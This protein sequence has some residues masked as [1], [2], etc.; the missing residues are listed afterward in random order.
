M[1]MLLHDS[2]KSFYRQPA[3]PLPA[4]SEVTIRLQCDE[5]TSV[6]LRTWMDEELCYTMLPT[7]KNVWELGVLLPNH[8]GLFWYSFIVY[9]ED[10]HT[11]RYGN[12]YDKLGGEGAV[13][14]EGDTESFQITVYDL[15]YATPDY[16]HGANIYQ[17]FPDRFWR[18]ATQSID[19][20]TDRHVHER[21]NEDLLLNDA[22]GKSDEYMPLDF[23]GGT[24][25]GIQEK[26][27][28]LKSLGVDILYLNPIFQASSNHRYDTGDYKKIDPLLG[29]EAEFKALCAAAEALGMRVMLDGVF[30]HTGEDSVYFNRYG[31]YDSVGAYQSEDSPYYGWY[32]FRHFPDDY[33]CWWNFVTLPEC[34]KDNPDYQEFIFQDGE[35]V[36]P[37][38][39]HAGACGWRLDV[40]DEL[41]MD[42]LRKLRVAAKKA[43]PDAVVLGEVWEDASNKVAY[44][45]TRCYCAGD[46]LDSV[47]NYPLREAILNFIT[48]KSTAYDLARLIRHQEEVYPA[49]FRYSLMNLLGSHDRARVLNVL[50]G[51][52]GAGLPKAEQK[53]LRLSPEEYELAVERLRKCVDILCALPGCPTIY[54]GDEAGLTGCA[55]PFC[56]RPYPWGHEDAQLR[57]YIAA[58]LGHRRESDVLKY[59]HCVV[60]ALD[61]DTIIITRT[62][63][64]ID[65]LGKPSEGRGKEVIKIRR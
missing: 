58:K 64:E 38:W 4:G 52:D 32:T 11:V 63:G 29:T 31:H 26:L 41:S 40:A 16:M 27:P 48:C 7:E 43:K 39:I 34:R 2:H 12:A 30:S 33:R 56:R 44:G 53:A 35:G 18:A 1:R 42:F 6:V 46:T 19:K 22:P 17:I 21:W 8:P 62:L 61:D 23:F 45:E 54:Y 10:G 5:A 24:L 36:V 25:T 59:G 14:E 3:G 50:C 28:Y 13:Y 37:R 15:N 47:M 65:A 9:R 51:R 49:Q 57:S 20:R 55:D 60:E